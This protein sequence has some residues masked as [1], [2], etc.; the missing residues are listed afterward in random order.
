[1]GSRAAAGLLVVA[2]VTAACGAPRAAPADSVPPPAP[3]STS[4]SSQG[5]GLAVLKPCE[6]L[7]STD[8]SSAGLTSLGEEKK[9]GA[10]RACDWTEPGAF[11]VTLTLDERSGLEELKVKR[12]HSTEVEI[13][14]RPAL[15]VADPKADNGMC[16]VLV[17]VAGGGSVHV[18]VSNTDFTGTDLACTRAGTVA[19]LVEPKLP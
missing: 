16:A 10:S 19:E 18:D 11:G 5:S 1:M 8:R 15:R 6:L 9:I 17:P 14:G 7:S 4:A 13:N 2:A 3:P 12:K